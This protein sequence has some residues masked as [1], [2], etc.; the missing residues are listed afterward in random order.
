MAMPRIKNEIFLSKA[1]EIHQGKYSYPD[2]SYR[3]AKDKI[4]I[5]CPIHGAFL[6]AVANH[7][8]GQGC[9]N[10]QRDN[11]RYSYSRFLEEAKVKWGE[12]YEYDES[13]FSALNQRVKIKCS[14]H[15]WGSVSAFGHL[16]REQGC[17][18]CNK[19]KF[20]VKSSQQRIMTFK[21]FE[22][23]AK[24]RFGER[25]TYH[26]AT[27]TRGDALTT[28]TC[29]VHG[30]FRQNASAHLI[31][32]GCQTCG[33]IS[34]A[35]KAAKRTS[36]PFQEFIKRA[37]GLFENRYEY[38]EDKY[39]SISRRT[40]I[41]CPDHGDFIIQAV[42]HTK[43]N[44]CPNCSFARSRPERM[45][46][47]LLT[48]A[49]VAFREQ[50]IPETMRKDTGKKLRYDFYLPKHKTIIEYDGRHHFEPAFGG[51][52]EKARTVFERTVANDKIKNEWAASHGFK[53]VRLSDE[54]RLREDLEE[55]LQG[56]F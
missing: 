6:Q 35:R 43:G 55:V 47:K 31:G 3:A 13:S 18:T 21:E 14:T 33:A 25:Y 2:L 19:E 51:T 26:E 28:I 10:C 39:S 23:R 53:L 52:P 42:E 38:H 12:L 11:Q 9:K 27:F 22:E 1:N 7:C 17:L 5:L 4:E 56:K 40:T 34:G 24:D 49:G 29:R 32:Q 41:T 16:R 30:N 44:G 37:N 8:A 50:W 36:V 20:R 46:R 48:A 54:R 15:G 45:I